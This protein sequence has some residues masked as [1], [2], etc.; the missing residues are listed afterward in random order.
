MF[1]IDADIDSSKIMEKQLFKVL[2][3]M[4]SHQVA[5]PEMSLE[6]ARSYVFFFR[7]SG[8]FHVYVGLYFGDT[9]RRLFYTHSANPF[10]EAAMADREGDARAFAED[11]GAMLD[12]I[13]FSRLSSEE[14]KNWLSEQEIFSGRKKEPESSQQTAESTQV[15]VEPQ[16]PV[17]PPA[18]PVVQPA[19]ATA[20]PAQSPPAQ[21]VQLVSPSAASVVQ[22]VSAA[23][24]VQ[25]PAVQP[26]QPV[27]MPTVQHAPAVPAVQQSQP[28][29]PPAPPQAVADRQQA[30]PPQQ[31][32]ARQTPK[33]QKK[34]GSP[35]ET[36][37]DGSTAGM[38]SGI[39]GQQH[40]HVD[41]LLEEAVKAGVVKAPKAQLKKD[42]RS[43][44]GMVSRDKE[45]LA[46]L[47]ASF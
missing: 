41:D 11:L 26:P 31:A 20:V 33:P 42:I 3:S 19:P 37:T 27:Q 39:P 38:E 21:P 18:T 8:K 1:T 40:V 47:L 7:E 32:R 29:P 10:P 14:K 17:E 5:N 44:T 25:V 13:D 36:P 34:T 35:A 2:F 12:E 46:R 16:L 4:N 9:D 22:P 43:A 6:D 30:G 15:A 23:A 28:S 24:P 45:A